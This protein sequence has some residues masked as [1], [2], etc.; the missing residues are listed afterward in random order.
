MNL[1]NPHDPDQPADTPP[2]TL[3]LTAA[4]ETD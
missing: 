1:G 3:T 2:A 4:G